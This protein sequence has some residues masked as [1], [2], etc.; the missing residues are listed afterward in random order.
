MSPHF[1]IKALFWTDDQE[2]HEQ[3]VWQGPQGRARPEA[4]SVTRRPHRVRTVI[5]VDIEMANTDSK[6]VLKYIL[7]ST[8]FIAAL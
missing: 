1:G 4:A 7:Y 3:I 2:D 5:T 8:S 6:Y